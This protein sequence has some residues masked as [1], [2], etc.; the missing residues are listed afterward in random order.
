MISMKKKSLGQI[1]YE[2]L[3]E[4]HSLAWTALP[5]DTK[6]AYERCVKA[7]ERQAKRRQKEQGICPLRDCTVTHSHAAQNWGNHRDTSQY[8]R[9]GY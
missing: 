5:D 4:G 7:V 3:A 1:A 9:A 8:R 6:R 2:S